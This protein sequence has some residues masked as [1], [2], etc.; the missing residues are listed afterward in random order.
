MTKRTLTQKELHEKIM[1]SSQVNGPDRQVITS[2]AY[3]VLSNERLENATKDFKKATNK[4]AIA[5]FILA[6]IQV[7]LVIFQVCLVLRVK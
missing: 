2:L 6:F 1:E 5:M 4:T 3:L 7:I